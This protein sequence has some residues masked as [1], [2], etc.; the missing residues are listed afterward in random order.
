MANRIQIPANFH[1]LLPELKDKTFKWR[2]EYSSRTNNATIG[3]ITHY[4]PVLA[5]EKKPNGNIILAPGLA[6]NAD[7]E[8]LMQ[9]ITYWALTKRFNVYAITTFLGDFK[10][11]I[12]H[13]LATQNT[14]SEFITLM[15][16]GIDIIEEQ[17]HNQ[18]TCLIGHSFGATGAIEIFNKRIKDKKSPRLSAVILFA[19]YTTPQWHEYIKS[20]YKNR[21]CPPDIT[22]QEFNKTPMGIIS[23]HDI[24]YSKQKRHITIYPTFFDDADNAEFRPD[25]MAQYNVPFTIVGGGRDKK[26]PVEMLRN[27]HSTLASGPNGHLFK[28]VEFPNSKH[29][30]IDQH[31]DY[32]AIINLIKSQHIKKPRTK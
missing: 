30:F 31:R 8:P 7:I 27:I 26:S 4:S 17:C 22:D 28:Y 15:D 11:E 14:F 2:L 21:N 16:M 23:P 10:P 6:S 13:E 5:D 24:C 3:Y 29:S 19:P 32:N 25:L 12:T 9:S 1:E 18:W 20:V